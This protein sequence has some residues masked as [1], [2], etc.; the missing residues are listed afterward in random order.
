MTTDRA[1]WAEVAIDAAAHDDETSLLR[2][3]E[4][5]VRRHAAAAQGRLLAVRVVL[6]GTT[7]LH[8]RLMADPE[9][10]R[11]QVEAAA[12]RC[13]D[14]VW[15]ERLRIDTATPRPAPARN[16]IGQSPISPAMLDGCEADADLRARVA[17][18]IAAVTAR[19]PGGMAG[20]GGGGARC[21][22]D[23]RRSARAY[24]RPH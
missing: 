9:R 10:L 22:I 24:A 11:D 17:D 7:R 14:D 16:R 18:L 3:V 2:A 4:E 19:L 8:T 6:A 1:R 20:E 15:L 13:A 23:S 5:E 21:R 12:Q